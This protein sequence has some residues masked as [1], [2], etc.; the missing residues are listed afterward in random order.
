[1]AGSEGDDGPEGPVADIGLAIAFGVQVPVGSAGGEAVADREPAFTTGDDL[2]GADLTVDLAKPVSEAVE[3]ASGGVASVDHGVVQ[4]VTVGVPPA[5][6]DVAIHG[7]VVV[8]DVEVA[9]G[10]EVGER[11]VDA[12]LA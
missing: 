9:G 11:F 6:E 4:P 2:L 8:Y 1:M 3:L 10:F 7:E 5:A 12:A